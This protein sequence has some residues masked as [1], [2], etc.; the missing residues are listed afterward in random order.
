MFN[1]FVNA[2]LHPIES[3]GLVEWM[4]WRWQLDPTIRLIIILPSNDGALMINRMRVILSKTRAQMR[5]DGI[6]DIQQ[7]G[8]SSHVGRWTDESGASYD[9]LYI[10]RFVE[11]RHTMSE[12]FSGISFG[13]KKEESHGN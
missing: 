9:V 12:V 3:N 8:I 6:K 7:F 1:N 5:R 13:Y 11:R 2:T 10:N 4:L